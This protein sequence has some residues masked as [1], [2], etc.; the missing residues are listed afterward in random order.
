M[1]DRLSSTFAALADPTR[2]A[3]LARLD[4]TG[5]LIA[6]DR[7]PEAEQSARTID[8][9]RF[10]FRRCWF[11]AFPEALA[12]IDRA[13]ALAPHHPDALNNRGLLLQA[14]MRHAEALQCF[15]A[16]LAQSPGHPK[17]L[18]NRANAHRVSR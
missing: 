13:L 11:S 12:S 2:R 1:A 16:A 10:A 6:L 3:I 5:R 17:M 7:D 4:S 8:D 15:D 9:P 14:Q 18:S